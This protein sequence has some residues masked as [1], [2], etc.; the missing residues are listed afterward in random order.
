VPKRGA[1]NV[2]ITDSL[3]PIPKSVT[4]RRYLSAWS[5]F[6]NVQRAALYLGCCREAERALSLASMM[7]RCQSQALAF[8]AL[9]ARQLRYSATDRSCSRRA[10]P[11]LYAASS[12]GLDALPIRSL[13][14]HADN[15]LATTSM[16]PTNK[17]VLI[18]SS[19]QDR[20]PIAS[21]SCVKAQPGPA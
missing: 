6:H 19:P 2:A 18:Y 15:P 20:A 4:G 10:A 16:A 13:S 1:R 12:E 7:R 14:A 11:A 17:C 5:H 8:D 21:R 3:P 9:V